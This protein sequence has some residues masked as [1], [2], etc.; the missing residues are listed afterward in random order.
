MFNLDPYIMAKV[1]MQWKPPK[2]V[3]FNNNEDKD[4]VE[5][6]SAWDI[7]KKVYKTDGFSGWYK[8]MNAQILKAVFCQCILFV[9]KEKLSFYTLLLFAM[10]KDKR[11]P[12]RVAKE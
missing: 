11:F 6:K 9:S 1:R 3:K 12:L 7:L 4:N 2:N 5:Y 10:L 8:G